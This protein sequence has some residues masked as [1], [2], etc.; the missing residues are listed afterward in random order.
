MAFQEKNTWKQR[1]D[2]PENLLLALG[3]DWVIG[4]I[5]RE[6]AG[7][8]VGPL[9]DHLNFLLVGRTGKYPYGSH[10]SPQTWP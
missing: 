9:P 5:G 10:R 6:I 2:N 1:H 7:H 3:K 4:Q 8:N